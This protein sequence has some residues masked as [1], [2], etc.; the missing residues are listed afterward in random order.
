MKVYNDFN[1]ITTNLANFFQKVS[2]NIS[3]PQAFNLSYIV[4]SSID[5]N[6]IIPFDV[7]SK[8]KGSLS[9]NKPTSNEKRVRRFLGNFHFNIY[10]FY[11]DLT[12]YVFNNFKVNLKDANI[13][14]ALDHSYN[15]DDFV[16][17]VVSYIVG[18]KSIPIY[19]LNSIFR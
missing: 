18:K 2:N 1:Y 6:S 10:D 19:I 5:A 13:F 15:K 11:N 8:F 9:Q 12:T 7:S 3:K 16:T 14:V 4:T 17:L